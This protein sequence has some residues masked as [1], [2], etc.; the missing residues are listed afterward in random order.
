MERGSLAGLKSLRMLWVVIYTSAGQFFQ[1]INRN[2]VVVVVEDR[3]TETTF[4]WYRRARSTIWNRWHTCKYLRIFDLFRWP[5]ITKKKKKYSNWSRALG[6]NPLYC[7]CNMRWL[8]EWVK[9]DYVEP[10]IARCAEP[11]SMKDKLLLTTPAVN[12]QCSTHKSMLFTPHPADH[13]FYLPLIVLPFIFCPQLSLFP[14]S[15]PIFS[16]ACT[17]RINLC[18]F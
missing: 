15:V 17:S 2:F 11:A 5:L 16:S 13:S 14:F 4:R 18:M 8:S 6:S 10:G 1:L 12:F 3:C 9:R 7:D